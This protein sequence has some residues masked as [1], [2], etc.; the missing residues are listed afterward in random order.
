[1]KLFSAIIVGLLFILGC[2]SQNSKIV[3]KDSG[4]MFS[5]D[6]VGTGKVAKM[7]DLLTIH[8]DAWKIE[9]STNLF[10]DWN[11]DTTRKASSIGG[12]RILNRPLKYTLGKAQFI[13]GSDEGIEGMKVGGWR[14]III[15]AKLAYKDKGFGP[16]PPNTSLKLVIELLDVK[17]PIVVK[18]WDVDKA[19]F[20]T[21][22]DGLKY[23]IVEKGEGA[24]IDSGDVV[25][26]HYSGY[27]TD[28]EKFDSSVERDEPLNFTYK[29]QPFIKGF[30]EGLGLM[31]KGT[32]AELIIPSDLAYGS[33]GSGKIPANST[34]IFDIQILDVQ[35]PVK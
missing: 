34:L 29:V 5:D 30:Q 23:A 22:K 10:T 3:K 24:K 11:K 31:R 16:I 9:D 35:K 17:D 21:T 20:K 18:K 2:S 7:G 12:T 6:T 28:G 4:L 13:K 1:M 27:F 19:K 25:T 15:P 8:F 33:R 32:K 14:T 26:L